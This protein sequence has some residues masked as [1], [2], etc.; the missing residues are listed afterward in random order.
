MEITKSIFREYDIRGEYPNQ[1]NEEVVRKIG[2]A[3]AGKCIN[4]NIKE[5]CVGRDGRNSGKSLLEAMIG[6]LSESG[7]EVINIDL[8]TSPLLYYAAKKNKYKSGIMITGSHNPKNHNGIKLVI[9]DKPVSGNEILDLL[10]KDQ[11]F[12]ESVGSIKSLDVKDS[13]IEEVS[14][15]LKINKKLKIVIDCGNGAA[16]FIA[17]DLYKNLGCEVIELYSEVDG[18]FPNHHPDP[19]KVEN[20]KDLIQA[21]KTHGADLGLAFDGD[22]DRVGMVTNNGEIV[23]PDKILMMLS[24]DVLHSQKGSIIFDVKCSNALS[25]IIKENG[26]SPIMSPTGHFHIKNGIKKHNPL[27]AGEMSG[28]IF[29]NDKWY[30]FDD[31]HYSG[32][33]I[34]EMLSKNEKSIAEICNELP[35]LFST[36]ELNINVTDDNKF[37]IIKEFADNCRLEGEKNTIDGLRLDFEDGWGLIRA[38]NT[39]PK[40]VLRFEGRSEEILNRIQ[41]DFLNEL[42]RICPDI[43]INLS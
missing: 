22:G 11:K 1:I 36:P 28:H 38:S 2:N 5:I 37:K 25:Q 34:I 26:G 7:I 4:L 17:P 42:T 33:R 39:T 15:S 13:Y 24:K 14:Q 23:F 6:G 18:N 29:F 21:V 43:D 30:G 19:G 41:N 12:S 40:L 8:A 32:A 20:L 27:L 16:G 31:G 9:D 35:M 10:N 3:I